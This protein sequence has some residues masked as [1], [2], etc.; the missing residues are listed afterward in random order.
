MTTI[1]QVHE[2]AQRASQAEYKSASAKQAVA[3]HVASMFGDAPLDADQLAGWLTPP[4]DGDALS[5][6]MFTV[7]DRSSSRLIG[8]IENRGR[9]VGSFSL[10]FRTGADV[11]TRIVVDRI[12]FSGRDRKVRAA[13]WLA[14]LW[15][16]SRKIDAG[17]L[18]FGPGA[19]LLEAVGYLG[20]TAADPSDRASA[21]GSFVAWLS[22]T[23]RPE[24]AEPVVGQDVPLWR[25]AMM[26]DRGKDLWADFLKSGRAPA[27]MPLIAY[28]SIPRLGWDADA[29][30][31]IAAA[32]WQTRYRKLVED[33]KL[34]AFPDAVARGRWPDG[35]MDASTLGSAGPVAVSAPRAGEDLYV[36]L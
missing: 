2:R 25:L 11:V 28:R 27:P 1:A 16:L 33:R 26:T 15:N 32:Y 35:V 29:G 36:G 9:A 34:I 3:D 31:T 24:L 5:Q 20:L 10:A 17:V 21:Q 12:E 13:G 8:K 6:A 14:H 7:D 4:L 30:E 18:L 19:N 22:E 23:G